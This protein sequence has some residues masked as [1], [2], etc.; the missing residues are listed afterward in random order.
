MLNRQSVFFLF[1]NAFF[2]IF[3]NPIKA[4]IKDT[5]ICKGTSINLSSPVKNASKYWWNTGENISE[6]KVSPNESTTYISFAIIVKDTLRDTIKVNVLDYPSMPSLK[7]VDSS[8]IVNNS[9]KYS[10]QWYRNNLLIRTGIDSLRYPIEGVYK[11]RMGNQGICWTYSDPVYIVNDLDST[12]PKVEIA[13]YPNP[14]TGSFNIYTSFNK[15]ISQEIMIKVLNS[16]GNELFNQKYFLYQ[17]N[18]FKSPIALPY[19]AKGSLIIAVIINGKTFTK[20]QI[21]N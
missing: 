10:V 17:S 13:T 7:I 16:T 19:G 3:H 5:S 4:L 6:I 21:V 8:I 15:R 11:V 1:F 14:S 2:L 9:F 20:Q 18:F 12:K